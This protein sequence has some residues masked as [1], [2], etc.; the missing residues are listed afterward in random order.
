MAATLPVLDDP[1]CSDDVTAYALLSLKADRSSPPLNRK[2]RQGQQK[3]GNQEYDDVS[4]D[5]ISVILIKYPSTF[6]NVY[7]TASADKKS[8]IQKRDYSPQGTQGCTGLIK[9]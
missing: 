5:G 4:N 2:S 8:K 7:R 9:T 3:K 1:R 6:A